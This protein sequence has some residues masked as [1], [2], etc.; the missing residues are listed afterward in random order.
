MNISG[1]IIAF[2]NEGSYFNEKGVAITFNKFSTSISNKDKDG[3]LSNAYLDVVFSKDLVKEWNLESWDTGDCLDVDIE[4]GF[5][6]FRTY[7]NKN[8]D[9]VYVYNIVV[10]AVKDISEHQKKET[11]PKQKGKQKGKK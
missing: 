1:K 7:E 2:V 8:G 9:T 11:E 5:L 4:T 10:T 3:N 6:T